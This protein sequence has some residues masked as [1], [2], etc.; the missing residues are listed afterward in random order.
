MMRCS[1]PLAAMLCGWTAARADFLIYSLAPGGPRILIE[2]SVTNHGRTV[3][4]NHPR[5]PP[6]VFNR[7]QCEI[8]SVPERRATVRKELKQ[9]ARNG[10]AD[11]VYVAAAQCLRHGWVDDYVA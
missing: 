7:E 10:S 4:V 8:I 6:T 2:G 11:E 5:F 1:L 3:T 9:A